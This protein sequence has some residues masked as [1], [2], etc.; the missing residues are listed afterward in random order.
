MLFRNVA[1]VVAVYAVF[2]AVAYWVLP[3]PKLVPFAFLALPGVLWYLCDAA[4][5][6][7]P[8]PEKRRAV[9][10]A[11]GFLAAVAATA[12]L[13]PAAAIKGSAAV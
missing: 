2:L 13:V 7:G 11:L 1:S 4:D 8:V 9:A 5:A 10:V 12:L 6:A 3:W